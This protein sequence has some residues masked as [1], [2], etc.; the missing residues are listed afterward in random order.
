MTT[1]E[2]LTAVKNRLY[3]GASTDFDTA[4][5]DFFDTAVDRLYPKIQREVAVQTATATVDSYGEASVD[6]ST[7]PTPLDD[8]RQVDATEGQR[9]YPVDSIYRHGTILR[10]RDLETTVTQVRLYGLNAYVVAAATVPLPERFELP[11][12]WFMMSEFFNMLAGNKSKFNAYTQAAGGRAVDDLTNEA[13]YY[14]QKAE[15]YIDDKAML[16]G[17]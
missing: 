4:L 1:A 10:I 9:W 7:L 8:V 15:K 14:E 3:L 11:V 16:Y 17:A 2:A 6:L 12:L 5:T 13:D